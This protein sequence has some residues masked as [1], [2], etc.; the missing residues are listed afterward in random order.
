MHAGNLQWQDT[1]LFL[2]KGQTAAV[3]EYV[4]T[5]ETT[6]MIISSRGHTIKGCE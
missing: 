6:A 4:Q 2:V 1:F 3:V 5:S